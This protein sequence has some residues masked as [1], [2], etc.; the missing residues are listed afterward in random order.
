LSFYNPNA[1]NRNQN[2]R[3]LSS[4]PACP[5]PESTATHLWIPAKNVLEDR[6]VNLQVNG[7]GIF[8]FFMTENQGISA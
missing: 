7:V 5:W 4:H 1:G 8:L 6:C 3:A 2:A